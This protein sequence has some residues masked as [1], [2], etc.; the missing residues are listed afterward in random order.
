MSYDVKPIKAGQ[1]KVGTYIIIDNEAYVVKNV[2]TAKTG[3]HGHAKATITAE[4]LITGNK[5]TI[6][7]PT[8]DKLQSPI[9]D[10]R[11]GQVISVGGD[12]VQIMDL[13]TYETIDVILP[14]DEA[15]RSKLQPG[16]EVEYWDI[17]NK[18]IIKRVK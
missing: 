6:V 2:D 12:S 15:L 10:K 5:K 17:L 1:V 16:A 18:K 9:I 14:D 8:S 11:N 3:K 4:H 7:V 13:E